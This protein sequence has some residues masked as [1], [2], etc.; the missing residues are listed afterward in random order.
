MAQIKG[1]EKNIR[2]LVRDHV[3]VRGLGLC[4]GG[5]ER[6]DLHD[7]AVNL[8]CSSLLLFSLELSLLLFSPE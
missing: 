5:L 8:R 3:G 1:I 2:G 6:P 4:E 7:L